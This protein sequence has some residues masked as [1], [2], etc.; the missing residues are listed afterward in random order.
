MNAVDMAAE[1]AATQLFTE[2]NQENTGN[3]DTVNL[4]ADS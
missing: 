3:S 2:E 4:W 1:E